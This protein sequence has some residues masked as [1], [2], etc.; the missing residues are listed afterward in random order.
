[1]HQIVDREAIE[2]GDLARRGVEHWIE[3]G[4]R[5]LAKKAEIGHG[6]FG[7]WIATNKNVLGF[8]DSTARRLMGAAKR[9]LTLE[10]TAGELWGNAS[11]G[12]HEW[13]T[14]AKYIE[15]ARR[16]LGQIDLDPASS[17]MAQ[18]TVRADRYFSERDDGLSQQWQGRVWLNPPYT[19]PLTRV[20]HY[21]APR[22]IQR[23]ERY[24]S[25]CLGA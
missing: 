19:Q 8:G 24:R 6:N 2:I 23:R 20:I 9:A 10:L 21:Q 22:R 18:R 17:E 12:S 16:V 4:R 14:P 13:Y 3:A 15:T 7:R 1:M 11:A 5:L 25:N